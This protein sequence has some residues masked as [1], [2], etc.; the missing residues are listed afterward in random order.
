MFGWNRPQPRR[1][2]DGLAIAI[3]RLLEEQMG[4]A[5]DVSRRLEQRFEG[6][7]DI[8]AGEVYPLLQYLEDRGFVTQEPV[9]DGKVYSVTEAGFAHLAGQAAA[10]RPDTAEDFTRGRGPRGHHGWH[11][12]R[13]D[14][15]D[16]RYAVTLFH[17][18]KDLART[19]KH[20]LRRG[21]LDR[22][23]VDRIRE[24]LDRARR[25]IAQT[26]HADRGH[27]VG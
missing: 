3:L 23:R 4:T 15:H 13:H 9:G 24:I 10:S 1:G 20:E 7:L 26:L 17:E 11:H 18:I 25:E 27:G 6:R 19:F 21:T 14:P 12:H 8:S 2:D 22:A 16:L 5:L